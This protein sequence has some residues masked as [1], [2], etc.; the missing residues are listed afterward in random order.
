[1]TPE[2]A[3][4]IKR[5]RYFEVATGPIRDMLQANTLRELISITRLV[6][7]K[8]LKAFQVDFLLMDKACIIQFKH[9]GGSTTQM[10]HSHFR[11]EVAVPYDE[12]LDAQEPYRVKP[13]FRL[14][15]D[16]YKGMACT[17]NHLVWPVYTPD[18]QHT[19]MFIQV[20]RRN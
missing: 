12:L 1:M 16:V 15:S 17:G 7:L 5:L 20:S 8:V 4:E 14:L 10:F 9:E 19:I 11:F 6:I 2:I 13:R 18:K 3:K